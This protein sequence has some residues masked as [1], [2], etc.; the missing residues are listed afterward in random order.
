M[1]RILSLAKALTTGLAL[2]FLATA[3]QAATTTGVVV[4]TDTSTNVM[5]IRTDDGRTISF[6][7]NDATT[8]ELAGATMQFGD[9]EP[10]ARIT[11]T[12]D[13]APSDTTARQIATRVE[14]A[15]VDAEA[16][17]VVAAN[18]ERLPATATPLPLLT[19]AAIGSI[20]A[21]LGLRMR[22]S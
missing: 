11:V 12:S 15:E 5:T 16:P 17:R 21:G 3:A 10:G 2:A 13:Q 6:E 14:I 20:L 22:R 1:N 7:R 18:A 9:L 8:I 4:S 19:L